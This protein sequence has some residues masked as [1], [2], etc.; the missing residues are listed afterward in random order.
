MT[1]QQWA[2]ACLLPAL[3]QLERQNSALKPLTACNPALAQGFT[4]IQRSTIQ[5]FRLLLHADFFAQASFPRF[6]V[7]H[8]SGTQAGNSF[9]SASVQHVNVWHVSTIQASLALMDYLKAL[10][11]GSQAEVMCLDA[12]RY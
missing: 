10:D 7:V 5:G 8:A 2:E 1:I 9:S 11:A 3:V 4:A 12:A 6:S